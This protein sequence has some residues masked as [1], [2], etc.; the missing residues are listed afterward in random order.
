MSADPIGDFRAA[1]RGE[2]GEAPETI[3]PG[4]LHRFATRDR[5]GDDAGFCK[6]FDDLRGGV[7]G[8]NR[9]FPGQVFTWCGIDRDRLTPTARAAM[10]RQV[11]QVRRN[12][13]TAQRARWQTNAGHIAALWGQCVPTVAG[14]PGAPSG[15]KSTTSWWASSGAARLARWAL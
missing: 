7:Y 8:C 5:P 11:E 9:Q 13:D 6:L 3:E 12:R 2:L 1:I 15:A 10:A 4:R 14:D